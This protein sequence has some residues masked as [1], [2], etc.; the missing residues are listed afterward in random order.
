[1]RQLLTD[2][3]TD[4]PG[5]DPNTEQV[6][7]HFTAAEEGFATL[8][9]GTTVGGWVLSLG[10]IRV[11]AGANTLVWQGHDPDGWPLAPGRYR[12]E[13]FGVGRDRRPTAVAPLCAT[14]D[15]VH[16]PATAPLAVPVPVRLPLWDR[17]DPVS[18]HFGGSDQAQQG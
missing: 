14:L 10:D 16:H 13:L 9:V 11:R 18:A 1:M 17:A 12:L 5:V 6:R 8:V 7:I 4:L 3:H 15:L 2:L